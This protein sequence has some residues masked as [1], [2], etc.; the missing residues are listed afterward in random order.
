M[1]L[2]QIL[3]IFSVILALAAVTLSAHTKL[4]QRQ[5]DRLRELANRSKDIQSRLSTILKNLRDP[6]D[7]PDIDHDI[8]WAAKQILACAHD[9]NENE[10]V[11]V[12]GFRDWSESEDQEIKDKNVIK[13]KYIQESNLI[14][15]L[16]IGSLDA[17]HICEDNVLVSDPVSQISYVKAEIESVNDEFNEIINDFDDEI[18]DEANELL[19]TMAVNISDHFSEVES[20]N[21]N[22]GESDTSE[23]IKH[24]IFEKLFYYNG[25]KKIWKISNAFLE[26]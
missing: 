8:D 11:I 25:Y 5:K 13:Q 9:T 7:N 26:K 1:D 18:F 10:I 4:K 20:F 23:E 14:L 17:M 24:E 21:I 19:E 22:V 2:F 15:N 6:F 16:R 12:P 3:S